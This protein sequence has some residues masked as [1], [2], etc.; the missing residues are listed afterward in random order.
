MLSWSAPSR[1]DGILCAPPTPWTQQ[2]CLRNLIAYHIISAD[3]LPDV[4]MTRILLVSNYVPHLYLD[5]D[6]AAPR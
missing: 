6:S 1:M 3:D 2:L 4:Y 5:L